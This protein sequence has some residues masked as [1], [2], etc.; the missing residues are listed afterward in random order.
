MPRLSGISEHNQRVVC[1]EVTADSGSF[2]LIKDLFSLADREP[3]QERFQVVEA[4]PPSLFSR[5]AE[6]QS[7]HHLRDGSP[8]TCPP[9]KANDSEVS[10]NLRANGFAF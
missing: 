4:T 6:A 3:G 9:Q 7:G 1:S 2:G 10:R 8:P 5:L